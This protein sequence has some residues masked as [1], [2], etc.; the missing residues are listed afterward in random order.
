VRSCGGVRGCVREAG[1]K[2]TFLLFLF[3]AN[4]NLHKPHKTELRILT[5]H[6]NKIDR[7]NTNY[8]KIN[9]KLERT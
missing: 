3:T 1:Q 2:I 6:S 5:A 4:K 8:N 9:E 7:H